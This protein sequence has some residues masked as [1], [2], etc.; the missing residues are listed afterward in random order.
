M[1]ACLPLA[2]Q[3]FEQGKELFSVQLRDRTYRYFVDQGLQK[4]GTT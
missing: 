4:A 1:L 2:F 3:L